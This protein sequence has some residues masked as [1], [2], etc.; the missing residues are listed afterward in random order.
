[1]LPLHVARVRKDWPA[2]LLG[3]AALEILMTLLGLGAAARPNKS[4]ERYTVPVAT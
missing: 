2:D 4:G 1:M 3:L